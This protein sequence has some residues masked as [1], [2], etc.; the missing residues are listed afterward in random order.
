MLINGVYC[1]VPYVSLVEVWINR[2][3]PRRPG[4]LQQVQSAGAVHRHVLVGRGVGIGNGNQRRQVKDDVAPRH[5]LGRAHG[6]GDVPR[7]PH[8]HPIQYGPGQDFQ[9]APSRPRTAPQGACTL[10]SMDARRSTR[11]LPMNPPAP[12]TNTCLSFHTI[13]D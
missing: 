2:S 3:T 8:L 4:R 11:W 7:D 6:I 1:A 5:G 10:A 9:E 13:G 12:V